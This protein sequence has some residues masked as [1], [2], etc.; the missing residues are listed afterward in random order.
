DACQFKKTLVF[1]DGQFQSNAGAL[2]LISG[3]FT[4]IPFQT[5]HYISTGM[6]VVAT[7]VDAPNRRLLTLDG[8]PAS[9]RL[10][11]LLGCRIE[12]VTAERLASKPLML[13]CGE[14]FYVRGVQ[15]V[16]PDGAI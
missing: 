12:E 11:Q 10:A 6:R 1:I 16:H 9:Q 5:H 2:L 3:P 13:R 14:S 15:A 4:A 7:D 8:I